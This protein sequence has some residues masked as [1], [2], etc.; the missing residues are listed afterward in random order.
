MIPILY[1]IQYVSDRGTSGAERGIMFSEKYSDAVSQLER[2]FG[3]KIVELYLTSMDGESI[4][5]SEE[6][7]KKVL[8]GK[9][10]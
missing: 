2:K 4:T 1:S 9:Q 7:Y 8:S 3:N 6:A 10:L 5:L